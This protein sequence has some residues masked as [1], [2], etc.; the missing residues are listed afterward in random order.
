MSVLDEQS[1]A[2]EQ[3]SAGD[4]LGDVGVGV[5]A[6][7]EYNPPFPL[8]GKPLINFEIST[9]AP[10]PGELVY[11]EEEFSLCT[12][13]RPSGS[14]AS[15]SINEVELMIEEDTNRVLFVT[16]YLPY[17]GWE[18]APLMP[19]VAVPGTIIVCATPP[20][21]TGT[22]SSVDPAGARW[23]VTADPESGWLRLSIDVR[24]AHRANVR[25]APGAVASI[26]RGSLK[27]L[28]L[29]PRALPRAFVF[30][31]HESARRE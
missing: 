15:M 12:Q 11:L 9:D 18:R 8:Q 1:S 20:I 25:F 27:E 6:T 16:G 28:W 13:P 5:A 19:P 26:E 10:A 14:T 22:S 23:S 21:L 24:E 30:K 3:A 31:T 29:H 17:H 4:G 7:N 2:P